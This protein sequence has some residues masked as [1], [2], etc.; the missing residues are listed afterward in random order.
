MNSETSTPDSALNQN[1]ESSAQHTLTE[2]V[3]LAIEIIL[4]SESLDDLCQRAVEHPALSNAFTSAHVLLNSDTNA[5]AKELN[6]DIGYGQDLPNDYLQLAARCAKYGRLEY[7]STL[8]QETNDAQ[9]LAVPFSYQNKVLAVGI[10]V[11]SPGQ[12]G[13][14]LAGELA[15]IVAKLTGYFLATKV[16]LGL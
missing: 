12:T 16:G 6:Y 15:P 7:S 14:F 3:D 13:S 4:G 1:T 8:L 9:M 2:F 5:A 10:L 11:L